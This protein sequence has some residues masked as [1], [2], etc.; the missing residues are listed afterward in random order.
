MA[1]NGRSERIATEDSVL[2]S[3]AGDN[4]GSARLP[5]RLQSAYKEANKDGSFRLVEVVRAESEITGKVRLH[6]MYKPRF[7]LDRLT[8]VATINGSLGSFSGRCEPYDPATAQR[9]F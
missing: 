7:R 8:G 3:I 6:G 9:K 4:T 2:F 5:R 1:G